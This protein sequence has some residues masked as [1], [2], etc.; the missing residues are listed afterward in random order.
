[1]NTISKG[2]IYY[3]SLDPIV[4]SEQNGTRPV[5]I[6]Q[7]DI[8]NKYSPTVIAAA[9][10]SQTG[11]NKLPTHI[12]IGSQDNGLKADSVVLTEQIRT[13]DKSRLKEKIGHID[14]EKI[15]EKESLRD[16]FNN[17]EKTIKGMY[18]FICNK[19][20]TVSQNNVAMVQD[21]IVYL[22]AMAY[23][24]KT[25]EELGINKKVSTPKKETKKTEVKKEESQEE[26]LSL[27]HI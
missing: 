27:I 18:E 3:A 8:G 15:K 12:E 7:N 22:W 1:M 4:G 16:K 10:T 14:D 17:E 2:D 11:K 5:V 13:I 24:N 9:I 19:A 21:N 6:I 26:K 20:R 23:F 25:N